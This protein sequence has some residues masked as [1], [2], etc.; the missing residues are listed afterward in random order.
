MKLIRILSLAFFVSVPFFAHAQQPDTAGQDQ[1]RL[2]AVITFTDN[3]L[4]EGGDRYSG[5]ATPLFV[6]GINVFT[7]EPVKWIF[8]DGKESIVSD[9][10]C[11]QNLLR[12][13]VSLS[14]ITGNEKY[15]SAAKNIL[16]YYFAHYQDPSG[17]LHWGGH[18]FI[19]LKDLSVVG[20]G[21]KDMVHELKNAFPYYD[22]WFEVHPDAAAKFIKAFWNAHVYNWKTFEISRH[23]KYGLKPGNIWEHN[24]EQQKPFFQTLGLSFLDAGDDLIYSG[25]KLYQHTHDTGAL[26]WAKRLAFQYVNARNPKTNL[27]AYQYT[28]PRKTA[29]PAADSNTFSMYGD[30]VQRQFGPEFGPGALEGTLLAKKQIETIYS[31]NSLMQIQLAKELGKSGTELLNWTREGMLACANDA[32]EPEKNEFR[33]M[34]TDGTDISNTVLK[35]DGYNGPKGAIIRPLPAGNMFLISFAR[36]FMVTRERALWDVARGIAKGNGLGDI[37]TEPGKNVQLNYTT[38]SDDAFS[39]FGLL[40]IFSETKN[41]EYLHLARVIGNNLVK[42]KFN[43][44]YFTNG[45]DYLYANVDAIEPYALLALDAAIKGMP[46]NVPGFING[47]GFIQGDYKF[48]NGTV[49]TIK[50]EYFFSLRKGKETSPAAGKA[51]DDR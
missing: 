39:I 6:N 48:P 38:S 44:G 11:Q 4:K 50:D 8:P 29:E 9:F 26:V 32:Y 47:A 30:R 37:G 22:F 15:K 46:D 45:E 31:I 49:R 21:E 3:V 12:V 33:A 51:N 25:L 13:L 23:G 42:N 10:A 24:F 27:G 43:H 17:L 36:A 34:F 5:K 28:Q 14:K 20:P 35:R 2:D 18:Q 19:D 1:A 16:Q 7:K 40:D 41:P